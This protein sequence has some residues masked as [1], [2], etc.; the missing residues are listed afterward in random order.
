[1]SKELVERLREPC[2]DFTGEMIV[3]ESTPRYEIHCDILYEAADEI[4]RLNGI[5]E[6]M[7]ECLVYHTAGRGPSKL[8]RGQNDKYWETWNRT[9]DLISKAHKVKE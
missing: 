1:M 8:I 6:E 4:E 7:G 2:K 9:Q 3:S 5:I